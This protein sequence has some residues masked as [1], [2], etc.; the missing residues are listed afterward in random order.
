MDSKHVD[1]WN[2][3]LKIIK[4]NVPETI[5]NSW[6]I[7]IVP[8]KYDNVAFTIQVPSHFFYE[9]L[10][11]RY[12]DLIHAALARII[13][14]AGIKL[15]Y[16]V[17]VDSKQKGGATT[18]QGVSTN[19]V[20]QDFGSPK[21]LNKSPKNLVETTA[22]DWNPNL[23]MRFSFDNFFEGTSN[24]LARAI[25]KAVSENPGKT[26]FNPF[27]IYGVSGVGKTH[28]CHAIGTE[29]LKRFPEKK[30][31]YISSHLFQ[32]QFSDAVLKN[33]SNDFVNFYQGVD[34]LIIDDIQ[35]FAGK[36]KTQ[37]TYFHIFNHL[38]LLGK[39]IILT[40]DKPP[41]ELQGLEE[42][43][44]SR[45]KWGMIA[46]LDK[47]DLELRKKILSSKVKQDGLNIAPD[48]INYIAEHVTNHVRDLEGI[49]TSLVA[50]SLVYNRK[51][52]MELATSTIEKF[53]TLSASQQ[54]ITV[55]KIQHIVS[56]YFKITLDAVHS[57]SRKREIVQ[58][59]QV[60]MFLSKKYTDYS[61]SL[62]GNIVGKRNH[63]TVLYACKAVQ[64]SLDI[65]KGFRIKMKDIEEMLKR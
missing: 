35:E 19:A 13:G 47:P 2:D 18:I 10:E 3:C 11:E 49:V 26:S 23:N 30:V 34:V 7:P 54:K 25:G 20:K 16:R 44:I 48:I 6:F 24:K 31:L 62:I 61:Y 29:I 14:K 21:G 52:D 33:T 46:E 41:V 53:V 59:R 51:I 12:A 58:A 9:F 17:I 42:R 5:Y 57:R 60:M 45:F 64:D 50:Q 27:F 63:A 28:L 36:E 8:L 1:L 38:H 56:D 37:N 55:E 65:D 43:L 40:S 32:V 22:R 39:Q 15:N 4:D